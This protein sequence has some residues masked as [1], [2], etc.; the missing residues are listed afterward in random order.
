MGQYRD[1]IQYPGASL[2]LA[3]MKVYLDQFCVIPFGL[4]NALATYQRILEQILSGLHW[5]TYLV[6]IDDILPDLQC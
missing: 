5:T 3:I 6:Y 4:T 1:K 2:L